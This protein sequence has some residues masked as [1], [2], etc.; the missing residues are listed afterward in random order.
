MAK[1]TCC[2]LMPLDLGVK[3]LA[4]WGVFASIYGILMS[5]Y[6]DGVWSIYWPMIL[7]TITMGLIWI[8]AIFRK[9]SKNFA[10]LSFIVL[11]CCLERFG[12]VWRIADGTIMETICTEKTLPISDGHEAL[13]ETTCKYGGFSGLVVDCIFGWALNIYFATVICRWAM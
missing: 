6:L 3:L 1:E 13:S 11:L 7:P 8:L 2:F 10:A 9:E 5:F 12:Y 4:A